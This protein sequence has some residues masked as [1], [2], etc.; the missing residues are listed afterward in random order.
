MGPRR[1]LEAKHA[2]ETRGVVVLILARFIPG[3]RTPVL[4]MSGL[5]H[6]PWWKFLAVE[7]TTVAVTAPAQIAIGWLGKAGYDKAKDLGGWLTFGLAGLALAV[8]F[9]IGYRWYK[10]A[11]ARKGPRP[12][13]PVSWLRT[14]GKTTRA[15]AQSTTAQ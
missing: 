13:A 12:R 8:A 10:Q 11:K 9:I 14:F 7:L 4:T 3:T 15:T 6:M 1:L 2:M 5:L